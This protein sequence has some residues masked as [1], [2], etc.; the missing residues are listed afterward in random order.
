ME[1]VDKIFQVADGFETPCKQKSSTYPLTMTTDNGKKITA[2][3][4]NVLYV[5]KLRQRLMSV[6]CL[7]KASHGVYFG[8]NFICIFLDKIPII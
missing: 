7:T 1:P 2:S 8:T 3:V 4:D 5:P 6:P